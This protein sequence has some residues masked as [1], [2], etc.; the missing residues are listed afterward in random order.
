MDNICFS[1][2]HSTIV[3]TMNSLSLKRNYWTHGVRTVDDCVIQV[4][5]V[6]GTIHEEHVRVAVAVGVIRTLNEN[7]KNVNY[8]YHPTYII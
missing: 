8:Q 5:R 3:I 4:A 7:L 6:S 2:A 1:K